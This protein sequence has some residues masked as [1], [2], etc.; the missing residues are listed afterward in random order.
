M[1]SVSI[2][3]PTLNEEGSIAHV[4]DE[5]EGVADEVI[6]VDGHSSDDTVRIAQMYDV[7]V[8][9]DDVGKGSAVITGLDSALGD[10]LVMMDA[11]G[12]H[13]RKEVFEIIRVIEDGFDVC[14]P[15]R[16]MEGGGS[17]DITGLRVFGNNFY[18]FWVWLFWG[19]LYTDICY[20][21]RGFSR[22]AYDKLGLSAEGFDIE[23]EISIK[24]AKKNL[25]YKEIPSFELERRS[26]EGKLNFWT[27]LLLDKRILLELLGI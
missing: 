6:I 3:I 1:S 7:K 25:R 4:L 15:S 20:G 16:F 23:L 11:D 19:I 5:I 27:S 2:I 9:F 14:M 18:K 10:V 24:T 21:F 12:S 17:D 26:G 8:L 22:K 13:H